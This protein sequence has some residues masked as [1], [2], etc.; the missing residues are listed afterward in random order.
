MLG[1]L[2]GA[3]ST[4][5][6]SYSGSLLAVFIHY[7]GISNHIFIDSFFPFLGQDHCTIPGKHVEEHSIALLTF[8][9]I[10]FWGKSRPKKSSQKQKP[11]REWVQNT[12][13]SKNTQTTITNEKQSPFLPP[14]SW[15]TQGT[16]QA[17]GLLTRLHASPASYT[18]YKW[19]SK[20]YNR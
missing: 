8:S 1:V 2:Q 14:T 10:L 18:K 7:S 11:I 5:Q 9:L 16:S 17:R 13:K 3:C 12:Y 6:S 19:I 20:R 4:Q 15:L